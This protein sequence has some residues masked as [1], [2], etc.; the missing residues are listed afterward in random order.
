MISQEPILANPTQIT[1]SLTIIVFAFEKGVNNP[2]LWCIE[3]S[4]A[5]NFTKNSEALAAQKEK[6]RH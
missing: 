2:P 6:E 1:V 4:L 3:P 5:A